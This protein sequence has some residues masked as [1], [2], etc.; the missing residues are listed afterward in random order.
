MSTHT[1]EPWRITSDGNMVVGGPIF[2]QEVIARLG[3]YTRHGTKQA[4]ARLIAAAPDLLALLQRAVKELHNDLSWREEARTAIA[5]VKEES[6]PTIVCLCGSSRFSEA[7]QVANFQETLAGKIVLSIGCDFKSD[8]V[9]DLTR[10]AKRRLDELH[11]RK[12]DLADEVLVLN[13]GDYIGES[14]KAE[15]EYAEA[16]NK[17]IRWLEEANHGGKSCSDALA[18]IAR[19]EEEKA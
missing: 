11:L 14:T 5:R 16:H 1:P 9:T 15:I 13:V 4:N 12:I 8:A 17:T 3:D 2:D 19:V 6:R 18:V 10:D 7:Y